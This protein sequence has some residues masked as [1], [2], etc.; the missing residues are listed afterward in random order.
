MIVHT[1]Q[2]LISDVDEALV[3]RARTGSSNAFDQLVRRH[4]SA[5]R[6][7][8]CRMVSE[9][10]LADDL[11]QETFLKAWKNLSRWRGADQ[12]GGSFRGWLF[13]IAVN[14]AHDQRRGHARAQRRDSDWL[15]DQDQVASQE[16]GL[17]A[18]LDLDKVLQAL[19]PDQRLVVALCFGAGLSH[20][21]AAQALSMPLGTLKSHAQR[22]RD[23]A[24][25]VMRDLRPATPTAKIDLSESKQP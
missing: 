10:S 8:L 9:P 11:A 13:S 12:A 16:T 20:A 24:I 1:S 21:E 18:K 7:F 2:T 25:E 3:K 15:A 14:A 23:R 5:V 4:Q 22:G 19:S 17:A 6:G